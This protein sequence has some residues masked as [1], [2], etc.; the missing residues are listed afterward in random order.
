MLTS[1]YKALLKGMRQKALLRDESVLRNRNQIIQQC[2]MQI[3]NA[4]LKTKSTNKYFRMRI[5]GWMSGYM[6]VRMDGWIYKNVYIHIYTYIYMRV[7]IYRV[8]HKFLRD[9]QPLRYSGQDGHAEGEDATRGRDIPSFC[10]A[11][12]AQYVHP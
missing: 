4:K 9:F 8:I 6:D 2:L 12:G 11:T 1:L 5:R 3:S 10:P 7:Y